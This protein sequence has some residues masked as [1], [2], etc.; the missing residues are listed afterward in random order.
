MMPPTRKPGG[1]SGTHSDDRRE[2]HQEEG[3][4]EGEGEQGNNANQNVME[5]LLPML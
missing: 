2:E 5:A 4:H 3:C 1:C